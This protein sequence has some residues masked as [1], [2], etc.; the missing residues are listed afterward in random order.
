MAEPSPTPL[1]DREL[2]AGFA[3]QAME[4]LQAEPTLAQVEAAARSAFHWAAYC[5]E[6]IETA[7]PLPQAPACQ[8]KCAFCCYNQV[9]LTT[10]EA[11]L[12]G[13]F[14][15][16]NLSAGSLARLRER[17]TAAWER[18]R[19]LTKPQ[20]AAARG[21]FPCP[22]LEDDACLA[23]EVRPLMCRA[24]HALEASDCQQEL[25]DPKLNLV[26][27]YGHRHVIHVSLSQGLIDA[28]RALGLQAG[29]VNLVLAL[30]CFFSEPALADTWLAQVNVFG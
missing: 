4:L 9:E 21:N 3:L 18:R 26:K 24:M 22:L 13:R 27:F 15:T 11:L 6:L 14:L 1:V 19:G 8:V 30:D 23:Y 5:T 28:C 12:L 2:A 20:F 7:D 16:A 29:P 17:V 10:P 25:A